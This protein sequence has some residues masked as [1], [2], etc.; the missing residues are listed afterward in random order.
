MAT[1]APNPESAGQ[2]PGP[3][4]GVRVLDFSSYFTGPLATTILA[5]QGADVIKVEAAPVGDLMR[6]FGASRDGQAATFEGVNR[7]KRSIALDLKTAGGRDVARRLL[8]GADVMVENFRPGVARRLG[9]DYESCQAISPDIICLSISGYGGRG[10]YGDMPVF[11]T[12]IQAHA[13]IAGGQGA[14]GEP[15]FVRQAIVDKVTALYAVQ[16][17]SAALY[18]RAAGHG[19]DHLSL[20][21]FDSALAFLWPDGMSDFTYLDG[22]IRTAPP[23]ASLYTM[24]RTRD[25][26]IAIA[27]ITNDQFGGLCRALGRPEMADDPRV[28]SLAKRVGER[29]LMRSIRTGAEAFDTADLCRRLLAEDVPH[30]PVLGRREVLE[31]EQA[32]HA[33]LH[34]YGPEGGRTRV[35]VSPGRFTR[36]DATAPAPSPRIG[37]HAR[38]I[39]AELGLADDHIEAL[40]TERA[41]MA[42]GGASATRERE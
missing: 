34:T 22:D 41:V 28:N 15:Q 2:R 31:S 32:R 23:P 36:R 13:G 7:S 33:N 26:H 6:Q 9:L 19:G 17:I 40:I 30:A 20:A 10:P 37:E 18:A 38:E 29:E 1:T 39:L 4:A 12:V 25:G 11:D 3:F 42:P 24:Q 27:A 14:D 8:A 35:A 5:D 21:M 16:L